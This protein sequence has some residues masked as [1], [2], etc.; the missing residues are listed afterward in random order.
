MKTKATKIKQTMMMK[1]KQTDDEDE[2]D[3]DKDE[4]DEVDEDE[5]D[6]DEV[7]EDDEDKDKDVC[8][9]VSPTISLPFELLFWSVTPV[10]DNDLQNREDSVLLSARPP[11]GWPSD[12]FGQSND[13]SG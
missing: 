6:K 9:R 2:V 8:A 4:V 12:P 7:D 13:S 10:E 1:T 11:S 5:S 3:K